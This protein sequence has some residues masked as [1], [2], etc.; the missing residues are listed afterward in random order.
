MNQLS[1]ES[2][3]DTYLTAWLTGCAINCWGVSVWLSKCWVW[4]NNVHTYGNWL[5]E[6]CLRQ[7]K[8]KSR[9]ECVLCRHEN[10]GCMC[11]QLRLMS[12][13]MSSAAFHVRTHAHTRAHEKGAVCRW[14]SLRVKGQVGD[15]SC[16]VRG[17]RMVYPQN[18]THPTVPFTKLHRR[19]KRK[20]CVNYYSLSQ[21]IINWNKNIIIS[22]TATKLLSFTVIMGYLMFYLCWWLL[23]KGFLLGSPSEQNKSIIIIKFSSSSPRKVYKV[24]GMRTKY[25]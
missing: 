13:S 21:L 12:V 7:T 22:I 1:K 17:E 2:V 24:W 3:Q 11:T 15:G 8:S 6:N 25:L 18:G 9:W 23:V 10:L 16:W 4:C 20:Y 19:D 5:Q 14:L